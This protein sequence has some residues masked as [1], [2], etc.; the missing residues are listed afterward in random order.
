[1]S[2]GVALLV[3]RQVR[4]AYNR[5]QL[6]SDPPRPIVRGDM[7]AHFITAYIA[8]EVHVANALPSRAIHVYWSS[9][10]ILNN[11]FLGGSYWGDKDSAKKHVAEKKSELV[12]AITTKSSKTNGLFFCVL[13]LAPGDYYRFHSPNNWVV[14]KRR[15]FAGELPLAIW[16]F[17]MVAVGATNVGSIKI[18]FDPAL[19]T[20]NKEDVNIGTYVEVSYENANKLL[21]GLPLRK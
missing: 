10:P 2:L 7:A 17:S 6:E 16:V 9:T 15:H 21:E 12:P 1:M 13:Y 19:R 14:E 8:L 4:R 11:V 18:N 20:N 3:L 5:Q